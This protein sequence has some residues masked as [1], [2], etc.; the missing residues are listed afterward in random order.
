MAEHVVSKK[1]NLGVLVALLVLAFATWGLA[2]VEM[3]RWNL[4][5]ALAIALAKAGLVWLFFM[6]GWFQPRIMK[7]GFGTGLFWLG[8]LVVLTMSDYFSRGNMSWGVVLRS[9]P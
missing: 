7:I 3:G 5:V 1:A 8:I 2:Y 6:H 4:V 9:R